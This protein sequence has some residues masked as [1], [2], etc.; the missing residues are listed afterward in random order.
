M[1]KTN[2][3]KIFKLVPKT[4][5]EKRLREFNFKFIHRIVVTKN[6]LFRFN[7]KS[8]SNCIYCGEPD[9]IDHTFLECQCTKSFTKDVLQWFN[10]ENNCNFK[11]KIFFLVFPLCRVFQQRN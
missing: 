10:V 6:E 7:I 3:K 1:E 11:M 8:D 9:S 5:R 2:W 4:C